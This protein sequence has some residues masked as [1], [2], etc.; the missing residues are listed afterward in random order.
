M[1]GYI[2]VCLIWFAG[3]CRLVVAVGVAVDKLAAVETV[4]IWERQ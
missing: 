3:D 2:C 1:L 4:D